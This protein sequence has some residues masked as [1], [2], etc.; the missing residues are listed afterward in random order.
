MSSDAEGLEP[1]GEHLVPRSNGD[2]VVLFG[3]RGTRLASTS[4]P[5]STCSVEV[6]SGDGGERIGQ[7][8]QLAR[9]DGLLGDKSSTFATDL[10]DEE[11]GQGAVRRPV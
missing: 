11:R 6:L 8:E 9:L 2:V 10:P 3:Q 1:H 4:R 5:E 7:N